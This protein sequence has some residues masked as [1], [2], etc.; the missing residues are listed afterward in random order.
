[1]ISIGIQMRPLSKQ[2]R[3]NVLCTLFTFLYKYLKILQWNVSS[4][5]NLWNLYK[6]VLIFNCKT[7]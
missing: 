4:P 6:N 3:L 5:A 7:L 2:S 1:M